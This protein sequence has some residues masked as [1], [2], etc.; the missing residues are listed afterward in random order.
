MRGL[1][2]MRSTPGA[3]PSHAFVDW[4]HA[5]AVCFQHFCAL[6]FGKHRL[7]VGSQSDLEIRCLPV[8]FWTNVTESQTI[9]EILLGTV[10]LP[11]KAGFKPTNPRQKMVRFPTDFQLFDRT[12]WSTMRNTRKSEPQ[13]TP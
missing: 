13:N 11:G 12:G 7:L 8:R 4:G 5:I 6:H 1:D 10:P 3:Y 9:H 2:A